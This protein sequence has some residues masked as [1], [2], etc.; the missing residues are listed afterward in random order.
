M[1]D[2]LVVTPLAI[3]NGEMHVSNL[4]GVG[5]QLDEQKLAHYKI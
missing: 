4:S 2:D 5:I 1:A 3:E